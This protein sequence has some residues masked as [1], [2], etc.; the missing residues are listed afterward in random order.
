MTTINALGRILGISHDEMTDILTR[1]GSDWCNR[2]LEIP[3][4]MVTLIM[5]EFANDDAPIHY[6]HRS[7]HLTVRVEDL[8]PGTV[9]ALGIVLYVTADG[10][11]FH[12]GFSSGA[13]H[14]IPAGR[15]IDTYGAVT[16]LEDLERVNRRADQ[17]RALVRAV[18]ADK[19]GPLIA[20][21]SARSRD[22]F[23]L[24]ALDDEG[25]R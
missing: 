12:V 4:E 16:A 9:T 19:P 8:A 7:R 21:A 6:D 1:I 11:S 5:R 10:P 15:T 17:A 25:A 14:E 2:N 20:T 22:L 24:F 18:Y 13:V 23:T 3:A